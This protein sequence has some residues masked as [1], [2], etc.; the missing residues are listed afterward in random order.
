MARAAGQS[1]DATLGH[2]GGVGAL[3]APAH[4]HRSM[5][6]QTASRVNVAVAHGDPV[7]DAGLRA[8]LH[9]RAGIE[10]LAPGTT[11]GADVVV[12]DYHGA[13]ALQALARLEARSAHGARA[14]VRRVPRFM[15]FTSAGREWDIRCALDAG[16]HGYLL[17]G[18]AADDLAEGVRALAHG[19]RYLCRCA[20]QAV[21]DSLARTALTG[22]EA[23]VLGLMAQGL[24]NKA[25]GREL[26][27]AVGTVKVHV[28]AVLDKLEARTRTQAVVIAA[29]RGLVGAEEDGSAVQRSQRAALLEAA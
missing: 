23:E 19:G 29:Q 9:G 13:L 14:D 7:V 15:V 12:A 4:Q 6:M 25:I 16:I 10:V 17:Q 20:M 2:R 3:P 26:G 24:P 18:C 8:L 11:A 27:I 22:R 5:R 1:P 28:K 21:A